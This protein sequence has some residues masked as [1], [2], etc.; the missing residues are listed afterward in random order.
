MKLGGT[1]KDSKELQSQNKHPTSESGCESKP[2]KS[3]DFRELQWKNILFR[4]VSKG[5]LKLDKSIDSKDLH[6]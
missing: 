5:A 6:P 1:P 4:L 3:I 2:D